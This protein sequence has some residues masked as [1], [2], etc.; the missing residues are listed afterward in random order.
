MKIVDS[1]QVGELLDR[2]P[3]FDLIEKM[4]RALGNGQA[5]QPP[6]V[7]TV[8]PKDAGD[9]IN[10]SGIWSEAGVYGIKTSP[11]IV[12]SE[13]PVIT[14]WTLLMSMKTGQPL[15]LVDAGSLTLERTAATTALAVKLLA[16]TDAK[17]LVVIGSGSQALAHIRYVKTLRDWEEIEVWS[18]K[19]NQKTSLSTF[20]QVD[21]RVRFACDKASALNNADVIMLC[22]SAAE[23]VID[24]T[25][26]RQK[27]LITSISTNAYRAHEIDPKALASMDVYCD[28]KD[29]TVGHAGE[30][31]IATEKFGW[32]PD[33]VKGDLGALL[34]NQ[35]AKPDYSKHVFFRSIG[36]GLEDVA[37][38]VAVL[39][40][41]N[42]EEK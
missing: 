6:Q 19:S 36:Q 23:P 7:Q 10:Y 37:C 24:I 42:E 12:T 17:K 25:E 21:S 38:A 31:L 33:A 13:K 28:C 34:N 15:L 32:N 2:I 40:K 39:T 26:L 8:F 11:Y 35:C 41:L 18:P 22:T 3:V 30:M 27:A 16:K 4:F 9:F 20:T 5:V 29:A 14:A 1:T